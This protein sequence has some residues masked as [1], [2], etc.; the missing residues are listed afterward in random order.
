[1]NP[2]SPRLR[3]AIVVPLFSCL[4]LGFPAALAVTPATVYNIKKG[5]I[6]EG[7]SIS[8]SDILVTARGDAG[9]FVQV[10]SGDPSYAGADYSGI[11]LA[12]NFSVSPG[13]RINIP[14]AT[15]VYAGDQ[16]LLTDADPVIN[17][18]AIEA[19][20]APVTVTAAQIATGV[21]TEPDAGGSAGAGVSSDGGFLGSCGK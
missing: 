21:Y 5:I 11:F 16:I 7:T 12:G 4:A 6:A 9:C 17:S 15:V 13:Q 3:R 19:P 20:P 8:L 2:A 18:P 14:A 10:K 1:M